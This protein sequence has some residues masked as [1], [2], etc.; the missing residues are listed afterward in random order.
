[1][2]DESRSPV[3][4]RRAAGATAASLVFHGV[5]VLAI[6]F[7]LTRDTQPTRII[8]PPQPIST[9]VF[10]QSAGPG[11]GG[12][13]SPEPA[14]AK[15]IEIPRTEA[16]APVP[17]EVPPPVVV[18]PPPPT[19]SLPVMT[20]NAVSFQASGTSLTALADRGGG[21]TGGGLGAGRGD[22]VG[23]GEGGQ[24][25][26]GL[27]RPGAGVEP[28]RLIRDREPRYT[29]EALRAKIQGEVEIQAIVLEDGTIGDVMVIKSLDK[30]HGLDIEAMNAARQWLFTPARQNGKPVKMAVRMFLRFAI[31]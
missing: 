4:T 15:P 25:G 10:L 20:S 8:E 24:F 14:P 17:L 3:R 31:H 26:G 23:D 29:N 22:G 1:M 2:F 5:L 19:L 30:T 21:G 7:L 28:P 6:A 18:P 11:G 16:P 27:A 12:G 13:G 9:L